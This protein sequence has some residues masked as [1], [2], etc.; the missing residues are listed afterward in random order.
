[1]KLTR[2]HA[3]GS[4]TDFLVD[5]RFSIRSSS[6][7]SDKERLFL[8][9]CRE[10]E[11]AFSPALV[12]TNRRIHSYH[13]TFEPTFIDDVERKVV[14]YCDENHI[15]YTF[16]IDEDG[17]HHYSFSGFIDLAGYEDSP[18]TFISLDRILWEKR[19]KGTKPRIHPDTGEKASSA[20]S[21]FKGLWQRKVT[22]RKPSEMDLF[23]ESLGTDRYTLLSLGLPIDPEDFDE[24]YAA[25]LAEDEENER[26]RKEQCAR[27][28]VDVR[29]AKHK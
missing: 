24:F 14:K 21:W 22:R 9:Y 23:Y 3:I 25:L 20:W 16:V 5:N 17:S 7:I 1:M 29:W 4:Q 28:K 13:V 10:N 2:Q 11:I 26:K 6:Y 27:H 15:A 18:K 12:D 8:K 19:N